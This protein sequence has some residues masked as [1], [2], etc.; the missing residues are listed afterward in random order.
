MPSLL[1]ISSAIIL[2]DIKTKCKEK[3]THSLKYLALENLI[4]LI[5]IGDSLYQ[6]Y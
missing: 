4:T 6:P 3:Q 1:V 5:T 2:K